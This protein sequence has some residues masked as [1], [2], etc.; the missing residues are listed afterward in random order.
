[1]D[2]GK[3]LLKEDPY[4][5]LLARCVAAEAGVVERD[6]ILREVVGFIRRVREG[7]Y[8]DSDADV[9]GQEFIDR[10]E[11]TLARGGSGDG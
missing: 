4:S 9:I 1:M 11:A 10:I 8:T 7:E 2:R 6:E 3:V 5:R